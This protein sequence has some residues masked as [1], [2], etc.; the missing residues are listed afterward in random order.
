[1][2]KMYRITPLEKKNVENV[3]DVYQVLPDGSI[4]G[5]T[6]SEWWRWGQGFRDIDD[7]ITQCDISHNGGIRFAPNAGW[8]SELDDLC[9]VYVEFQGE[10]TAAEQ[11]EITDLVEYETTDSEGRN[12]TQWIF[13][14]DHS[15]LVEEDYV[16]IHGPVQIDIVNEDS[17]NE[18]LESDIDPTPDPAVQTTWPFPEGN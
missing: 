11:Q 17:Y 12:G 8:G 3:I 13:D 4:R 16:L 18:T 5:F 9:S 10:F 2:S 15:W 6:V 7:P 1:M 14:G